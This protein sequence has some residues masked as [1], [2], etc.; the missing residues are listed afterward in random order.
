MN[1]DDS[2]ERLCSALC[3]AGEEG[4]SIMLKQLERIERE[5][6]VY[7]A[8][9]ELVSAGK[10]ADGT[11]NRCREACEQLADDALIQGDKIINNKEGE[12]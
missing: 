6:N 4:L 12:L 3:A 9:L 10:R 5:R 7:R 11:Y 8:A 1:S 2:F